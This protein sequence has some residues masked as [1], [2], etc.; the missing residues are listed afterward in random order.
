VYSV[1]VYKN[2]RTFKLE[3][4]AGAEGD[5]DEYEQEGGE[6]EIETKVEV[7]SC[8]SQSLYKVLKGD[9]RQTTQKYM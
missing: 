9:E 1:H 2:T 6:I 8:R 5:E 7:R 4:A 3:H